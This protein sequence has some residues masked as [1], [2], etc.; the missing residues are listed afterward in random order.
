[1]ATSTIKNINAGID[2]PYDLPISLNSWTETSGKYIHT[3]TDSRI[4]QGC[5]IEV[6]FKAGTFN[7]ELPYIEFEK[8]TG[9]I[10]FT[11]SVIPSVTVPII[12]HII[13]AQTGNVQAVSATDV[14]TSGD[15]QTLGANVNSSLIALNEK[16]ENLVINTSAGSTPTVVDN[17]ETYTITKR[18]WY[19]ISS[20]ATTSAQVNVQINGTPLFW[21]P[22]TSSG[23]IVAFAILPLDVGV[24]ITKS[25]ASNANFAI[26]TI[27]EF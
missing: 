2:I 5:R 4:T 14:A 27:Q 21:H 19:R 24:V 10:D 7:T 26:R 25:N 1:M 13:N 15:A 18:G 17:L 11:T 9:S 23:T 6:T 8:G 22:A 16:F 3:Y 20:T 12:I